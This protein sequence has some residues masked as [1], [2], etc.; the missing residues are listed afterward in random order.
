M[1]DPQRSG[2]Q[3]RGANRRGVRGRVAVAPAAV[4]LAAVVA[5]VAAAGCSCSVPPP[6]GERTGYSTD[7]PPQ[8]SVELINAAVMEG[9]LDYS[10][11][12]LY[13][14]YV[15]YDPDSLP[16]EYQSDVPSRCGTPLIDEVRRNW[17]VVDLNDRAEIAQYIQPIGEPGPTETQ[18]DD[19]TPDRL[20]HERNSLD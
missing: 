17:N 14:V 10:T 15:M 12:L 4:A 18:L 2:V 6:D 20:D 7:E 11:S 3:G 1:S 8:S 13:K 5:L 9:Q 16:P 19:V